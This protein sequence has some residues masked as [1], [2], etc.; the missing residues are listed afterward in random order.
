MDDRVINTAY[1]HNNLPF[2]SSPPYLDDLLPLVP[3]A[4][5]ESYPVSTDLVTPDM[6]DGQTELF[7]R[8]FTRLGSFGCTIQACYLSSLVTRHITDASKS[9]SEKE[10]EARKLDAA[11]QSLSCVLIPPPGMAEG[12]Y[13]GAYGLRTLFVV[14]ISPVWCIG[15]GWC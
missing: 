15:L 5:G 1:E 8:P 6:T 2:A 3:N 7:N 10:V 13:C 11:L 4:N 12:A 14:S 9:Y